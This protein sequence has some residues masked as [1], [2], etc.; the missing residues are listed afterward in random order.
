MG[1]VISHEY[2]PRN[3]LPPRLHSNQPNDCAGTG[4]LSRR[5]DRSRGSIAAADLVRDERG[6]RHH[7]ARPLGRNAGRR[8][9]LQQAGEVDGAAMDTFYDRA[10]SLISSPEARAAFD[11][12]KE[13]AA[14]RENTAADR[15]RMLLP[16]V[17]RPRAAGI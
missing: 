10:Y 15:P 7:N 8:T 2:G 6:R 17:V 11:I 14:V 4:Y 9:A 12:D 3:N 1:S 5:M 16:A 13:P